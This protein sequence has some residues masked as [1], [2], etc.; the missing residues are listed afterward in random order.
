[1]KTCAVRT[2]VTIK[3]NLSPY[4][5]R[6]KK[7]RKRAVRLNPKNKRFFYLSTYTRAPSP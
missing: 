4:I 5:E 2:L 3:Y 1:M 6:E 7:E